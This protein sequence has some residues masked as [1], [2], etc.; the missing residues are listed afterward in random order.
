MKSVLD[1]AAFGV[2]AV[3]LVSARFSRGRGASVWAMSSSA[4][5]DQLIERGNGPARLDVSELT[6]SFRSDS[7]F[8]DG[9]DRSRPRASS[10]CSLGRCSRPRGPQLPVRCSATPAPALESPMQQPGSVAR[11]ANVASLWHLRRPVD[12]AASR[13]GRAFADRPG[14][15]VVHRS[16]SEP[17]RSKSSLSSAER[18]GTELRLRRAHSPRG[19]RRID[20]GDDRTFGAAINGFWCFTRVA[21]PVTTLPAAFCTKQNA[22]PPEGGP[23]CSGREP[24]SGESRGRLTG[25]SLYLNDLAPLTCSGQGYRTV[26]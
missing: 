19:T 7:T 12:S 6:E 17:G 13:A 26:D 8:S 18:V 14:R 15:F 20:P 11:A 5:W 16:L 1:L 24:L 22:G 23:A 25:I 9:V 21:S 4:Y 2:L 10:S 3:Q